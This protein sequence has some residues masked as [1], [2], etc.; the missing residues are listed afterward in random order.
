MNLLLK[1]FLTMLLA[2]NTFTIGAEEVVPKNIDYTT[3]PTAFNENPGSEP[4]EN[5]YYAFNTA[6]EFTMFILK[7][8]KDY[9][10]STVVETGTFVGNSTLAFSYI[11]DQVHTIEKVMK[12]YDNAVINFSS[13]SNVTVHQGSSEAVLKNILPSLAST[14]ILFYLDAHWEK[15]FPL[16]DELEEISKTHKDNCIIVIDDIKVPGRKE[17]RYCRAGKEECSY[18]Y[19]KD[20]LDKVFTAYDAYYLIPK[21]AKSRAKF[22]AIPKSL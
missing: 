2:T 17:L 1:L 12:H 21:N 6:P 11:F 20:N 15:Y 16:L 4:W 5:G 7:L 3:Y 18:A 14:T 19:V 22:V 8:K 10:I 9:K 13:Y